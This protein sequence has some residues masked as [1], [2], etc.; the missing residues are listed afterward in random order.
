MFTRI[1][2]TGLVLCLVVGCAKKAAKFTG[3]TDDSAGAAQQPSAK[4]KPADA[5][6][7]TAEKPNWLTDPRARAEGDQLPTENLPG[8]PG[9]GVKLPQPEPGGPLPPS[10]AV[11]PRNP[12]GVLQPQPAAP[13]STPK[14]VGKPVTEA[15]MKEVWIFMENA[16]IVSGKL[17][18]PQLVYAALVKAEA[19]AAELVKDGSIFFTGATARE[20]VW[21]FELKAISQGGWV[22]TQN[23]VENLTAAE[24]K[25]RLGR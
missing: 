18:P 23:G 14:F 5:S 3:R 24:L 12:M 4:P 16:S 6:D 10:G 20:S 1:A 7:K 8:K 25:Q 11:P 15:D 9:L 19:K 22:A 21:A 17:P 13:P 2:M